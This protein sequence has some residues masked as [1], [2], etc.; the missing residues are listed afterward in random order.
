MAGR[1]DDSA[2]RLDTFAELRKLPGR[3]YRL[4]QRIEDFDI[5]ARQRPASAADS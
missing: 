5:C 3:N 4:A 2:G 1:S